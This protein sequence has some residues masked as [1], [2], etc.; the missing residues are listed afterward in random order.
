MVDF[1][2]VTQHL[3]QFFKSPLQDASR[4]FHGRGHCFSGLE[5]ITVDW[6]APVLWVVIYGEQP[7]DVI[8]AIDTLLLEQANRHDAIVAVVVQQRLRPKPIQR[9]IYGE[10]PQPLYAQENGH[11]FVLNL[12]DNQNTGFFLDAKPARDWVRQEA[13]GKKI[14]NLFAYTCSFSVAA[15]AGD[16]AQVVNID[17][18][19]SAI[20]TGQKN[21]A[22]NGFSG[23]PS[24]FLAHDI[25]KSINKL[26]RYGPFDLIII[27]PPSH[28]K[29]GFIAT[30]DYAKLL[31][32]IAPLLSEDALL[33]LCLNAPSL[34]A[35]FISDAVS[36][37]SLKLSRLG[38]LTNRADFPESDMARSL[39]MFVYVSC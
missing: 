17:M 39:K 22:I 5:C 37:S 15:L 16:A 25:F 18:A 3:I 1:S 34:S 13:K 12:L 30:K 14:L 10:V 4:V 32:K 29:G 11:K 27:D 21:H 6:F 36:E 2:P 35:E 26:K 8:A 28:Q 7:Q 38:R 33:L 31:R 23:A 24:V 19:K 20:A 9:V